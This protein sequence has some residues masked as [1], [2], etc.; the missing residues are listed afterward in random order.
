MP[1][2][3]GGRT[4]KATLANST[5]LLMMHRVLTQFFHGKGALITKRN[6]VH[7]S[8]IAIAILGLLHKFFNKP[9]L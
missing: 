2:A 3:G 8:Y 9:C 6:R 5:L 7:A 4:R 1:D